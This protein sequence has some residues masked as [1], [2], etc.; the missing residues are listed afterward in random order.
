MSSLIKRFALGGKGLETRYPVAMWWKITVEASGPL[1]LI[2]ALTTVLAGAALIHE[3]RLERDLN[4]ARRRLTDAVENMADGLAIYDKDGQLAFHNGRYHEIFPATADVRTPGTPLVSILMAAWERGEETPPQGSRE[5]M[6]QKIVGDLGHP[7]DRLFQLR[8]GRWISARQRPTADH[9]TA[10]VYCDVTTKIEHE[11]KLIELNDMLSKLATTDPLTGLANRRLFEQQ[12]ATALEQAATD[13]RE[14]SL[15]MIDVDFF[16]TFNDSYG[17]IAGDDC[18]RAI[19]EVAMTAFATTPGATAARYGGEELAVILPGIG[20][21]IAH[22]MANLF[23]A[24]IRSLEIPHPLSQQGIVTVSVG[25]ASAEAGDGS[26]ADI[27]KR[28][29]HA[30]YQA[31]ATG[32]DRACQYIS[33]LPTA[34]QVG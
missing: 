33:E 24:S 16:K 18:L 22:A 14:L 6:A 23:V 12:L 5:A 9:G 28:A 13:R 25:V 15:L 19:A 4:L 17:H 11:S 10:V 34:L 32:R 20:A 8:D 7:A 31:K 21:K 3:Y 26:G 27:V 2:I 29:D 30:L 1:A